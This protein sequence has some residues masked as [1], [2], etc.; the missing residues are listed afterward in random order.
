MKSLI[1]KERFEEI[2]SKFEHLKPL[3]VVGDVG[4]DKYTYGEVKRISPEAPVPVLEVTKEWLKLGLSANISDNL[5]ALNINSTLCGVIGDDQNANIFEMLLEDAELST[6][7]MVRCDQRPTVFKE[8]VTTMTQQIC[9]IDYESLDYISADVEKRLVDRI[10]DLSDGHESLILEDYAKGT[11]SEGLIQ[12]L[13]AHYNGMNKLVAVD[14]SRTTPPTFYKG[15]H[16]LKPNRVEAEIMVKHLGYTEKK[17]EKIAEIL[18]EKLAVEKL[19]VTLGADGMALVDTKVSNE[20]SFIPTAAN[21]VFD[22]SG[23][24]D[25][26]I[27]LLVSALQAG[28]TLEEAAWIGNCGSGVV[29]GK[30][31]TATVNQKELRAFYQTLV[32]RLNQ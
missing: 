3:L 6:W 32:Q 7:G 15:V 24:G 16:L 12:K 11:L 30:K 5:K 8:R 18:I 19:V 21:E 28:A 14:P 20:V 31:G 25:T 1:T 29:V 9:R 26:A 2:V 23:A 17:I 27:A 13:I 4:I 10:V 22:V